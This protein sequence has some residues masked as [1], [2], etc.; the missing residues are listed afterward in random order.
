MMNAVNLIGRLTADPDLATRGS[1]SVCRMRLAIQRRRKGGED[2]GAV[3]VDLVTFGNQAEN[4]ARYLSKGS[5]V[6]VDGRL[7]H[8]EWKTPNGERRSKHEVI[9]EQVDFL[10]PRST[11][12]A[13]DAAAA[14]REQPTQAQDQQPASIEDRT[15]DEQP[16][17]APEPAQDEPQAPSATAERAYEPAAA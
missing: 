10:S 8:G 12:V 2:Q 9:V 7:E 15:Q 17:P 6:A 1:M 11:L 5:L 3:F 13:R 4:C 14:E 16:E